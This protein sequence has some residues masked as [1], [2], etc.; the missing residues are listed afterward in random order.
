[1]EIPL[2]YVLVATVLGAIGMLISQE[3]TLQEVVLG[4]V[5]GAGS[6]AFI[7]YGWKFLFKEAGMGVGDI[8]LAGGLGAV[9]GYPLIIVN[10]LSAVMLGALVG[11]LILGW[12]QKSL[13]TAIPFGP[14][15]SLGLLIA[16]NWGQSILNWYIL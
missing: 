12:N 11:L 10:L 6:L 2:E 14:F 3:L 15:L 8:W 4:L 16:L 5:V 7:L 9:A 13:K 1:M